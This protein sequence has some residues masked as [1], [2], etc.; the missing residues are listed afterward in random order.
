MRQLRLVHLTDDGTTLL[1]E[2]P[3]AGEQFHL[4]VDAVLRRAV[5]TERP[6]PV[7][8][9]DPPA[10]PEPG[11]T[12]GPREIQ[13]RVRAGESP[14]SLAQ[15]Y[16]TPLDRIQ[17]FAAPVVDERV[18]IAD[19]ARRGRARRTT[20]DGQV[21]V[22]GEAVDERFAAHGIAPAAVT[23]DAVRPDTEWLV[24]ARWLGGEE[25]HAAEWVFHRASRTVTPVDD[26]AI[27]LLSDRPIRP[28]VAAEPE[29]PAAPALPP[30]GPGVFVFPPMPDAATGPVP[31]VEEVFDQDAP[32]DGPRELPP[33]VPARAATVPTAPTEST[34]PA[35]PTVPLSPDLPGPD[36]DVSAPPDLDEPPLPLGTWT[37]SEPEPTLAEKLRRKP[38]RRRETAGT[39][40]NVPSWDDI[41]LGVRRE[42]E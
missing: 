40:T 18:R 38:A 4:P 41:L 29:P 22:F 33:L 2:S 23:W 35:Q 7:A 32:P 28:I 9:A 36:A 17:R 8:A 1:L 24:V 34:A 19:E 12:I 15:R 20:T 25:E 27:D 3:D 5:R 37:A 16:D 10:P 26:T 13:L 21:V 11:A 14:E 31:R 39:R 6:R 42:S 30:F